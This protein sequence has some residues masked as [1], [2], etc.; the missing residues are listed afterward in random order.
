[1]ASGTP[2]FVSALWENVSIRRSRERTG[3]LEY[4]SLVIYFKVRVKRIKVRFMLQKVR[5]SITKVRFSS[6]K[7]HL[8]QL[9]QGLFCLTHTHVRAYAYARGR[10]RGES[11]RASIRHDIFF[12]FIIRRKT[13]S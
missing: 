12:S 3:I 7:V 6:R 4:K 9:V 1:M 5:F 2:W 8:V 11:G 10:E 13:F